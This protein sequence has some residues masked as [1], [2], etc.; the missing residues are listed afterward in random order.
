MSEAVLR[1]YV[2][3]LVAKSEPS[4][5]HDFWSAIFT[6]QL[7]FAD[8]CGRGPPPPAPPLGGRLWGARGATG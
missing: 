2:A 7:A 6:A 5:A 3:A 1:N 4:D 8:V